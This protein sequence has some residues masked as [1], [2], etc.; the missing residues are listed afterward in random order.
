MTIAD[1]LFSVEPEPVR[2]K[3]DKDTFDA[4]RRIPREK[5]ER[6]LPGPCRSIQQNER[7]HAMEIEINKKDPIGL[8]ASMDLSILDVLYGREFVGTG[9]TVKEYAELCLQDAK[10]ER[11]QANKKKRLCGLYLILCC[12]IAGAASAIIGPHL[13]GVLF[14]MNSVADGFLMGQVYIAIRKRI[15]RESI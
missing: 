6:D 14:I 5:L 10:D 12:T 4:L 8:H 1:F 9:W 2:E 11:S 7:Q 3:T 13:H 15:M